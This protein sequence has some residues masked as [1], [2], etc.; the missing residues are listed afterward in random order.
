MRREEI[1]VL[2]N[3]PSRPAQKR[4]L[5]ELLAEIDQLVHKR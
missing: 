2:V 4:V 3:M 1:G 5:S